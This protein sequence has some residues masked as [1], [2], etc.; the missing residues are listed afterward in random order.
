MVLHVHLRR[1]D[2]N[3]ALLES[4]VGRYRLQPQTRLHILENRLGLP[5]AGLRLLF[6]RRTRSDVLEERDRE[7]DDGA[8]VVALEEELV[9][10]IGVDRLQ[11]QLGT[12]DR[13]GL[14]K[15]RIG[16]FDVEPRHPCAGVRP[17]DVGHALNLGRHRE[18]ILEGA[19]QAQSVL[20]LPPEK[21]A[22]GA[23][24]EIEVVGR[25]E[26]R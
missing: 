21:P 8:R 10:D 20:R 4:P 17:D 5:F 7:V 25:L 3:D 26:R 12:S 11:L 18:R 23:S 19:A 16:P 24:G 22:E 1:L 9:V 6:G 14:R 2:G 15:R 13:A